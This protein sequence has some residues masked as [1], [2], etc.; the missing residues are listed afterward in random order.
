M[1]R[2]AGWGREAVLWT[3]GVLGALCLAGF[4]A[5]WLFHVTPLV[6][7]SGSMSPS[8]EA[9][10]LGVA[11]EVPAADISVGDV[12]S[13]VGAQGH[14]VTHRVV[15]AVPSGDGVALT[16]Q[17]DTN[18]VPDAETYVV[19]AADRVAFGIPYAGRVLSAA[20]SP[21][22]LL[23]AGLLVAAAAL[24]GFGHRDGG[25]RRRTTRRRR[26]VVPAGLASVLAVG[27]VVGVT[28]GGPWAFTSAVWTDTATATA[29]IT[30]P[31]TTPPVLTSP[32]PSNG[33]TGTSWAAISCSSSANQVCVNA[34]DTAGSGVSA[35]AVKL[36]R[37]SGT[38]QCWDGSAF[39]N[40]TACA[41]QPMT[42]VSGAQY[43]SSGLTAALMVNG[44]YQTTYSASDV[45]GNTATPL[46]TTFTV[47]VPAPA[48][49]VITG[50]TTIN[51]SNPYNLTWTWSG[52]GNP[53]SF[54]LY[55]GGG[56]SFRSPT[57]FAGTARSGQT[58]P[59][60]NEAGT[61]RLVAVTGGV[62][63][64]LSNAANYSGNGNKNCSVS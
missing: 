63:S 54:K 36:V 26:L 58:Q 57:T 37:T 48:T 42:V 6:F 12:V 19:D 1:T 23:A 59:I 8:Y 5:G 2:V 13:V 61:F 16:L 50:C 14:R 38:V 33:A 47:A 25:A 22:G 44:T 60:N 24:L 53:D 11:R 62:E 52:S 18:N 15:A 17:G 34:T 9:G 39:V 49:P 31:D 56:G 64:T 40:G 4:V 51:G 3:G 55:Y 41:A 10:A 43:R 28:G 7:V 21:A 20:S 27:G 45:A 46:V 32:A 30:T 35:V 29:T